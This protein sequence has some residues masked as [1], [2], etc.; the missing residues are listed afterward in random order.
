MLL[1]KVEFLMATQQGN[2]RDI[3]HYFEYSCHGVRVVKDG[4]QSLSFGEYLVHNSAIT[5]YDLFL[6]LQMQDNNPGVRLGECLAKMG[7]LSSGTVQAHVLR[8]NKVRTI[9]A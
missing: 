7:T 3:E 6:A 1:L 4:L 2:H 9:E 5:R 8:W